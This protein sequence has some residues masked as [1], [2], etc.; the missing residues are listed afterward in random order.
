MKFVLSTAARSAA[1]LAFSSS[2]AFAQSGESAGYLGIGAGLA[3][4]LAALGGGLG[5]GR[6]AS[7][8]LEGMARNPQAAGQLQ[9]PMILGLVFTETLSL[10]GLII[11]LK[12]AGLI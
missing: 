4:G 12:L 2:V 10:F 7:A 9:T 11:A 5:Q 3:I 1:L 6:T 8:A